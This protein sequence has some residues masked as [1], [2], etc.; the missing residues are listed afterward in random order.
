MTG[1]DTSG[2]QGL[3]LIVDAADHGDQGDLA[4]GLEDRVE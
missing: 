3:A 2:A 1:L 4:N